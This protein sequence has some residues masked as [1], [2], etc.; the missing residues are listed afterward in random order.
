MTDTLV[1][2]EVL[3]FIQNKINTTPKNEIVD[4]CA[5]F[6]HVDEIT[7]A[8][9]TLESSLKIRLSKRN[10][11]DDLNL[12]LLSDVYDKLWS[13]D[14]NTTQI[15]KFVASDLSRIPQDNPNSLVSMEQV[16][17]SIH[18]I[19]NDMKFIQ[20]KMLTRGDLDAAFAKKS[21]KFKPLDLFLFERRI[22]KED[23]SVSIAAVI[24]ST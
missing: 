17:A 12:K 14:A 1:V 6:F 16:L 7:A 11:S 24:L 9:A 21:F 3:C 4:T 18:N 2:N 15:P 23:L 5:K 10:R 8:I 22:F 20:S 19:K 13:L